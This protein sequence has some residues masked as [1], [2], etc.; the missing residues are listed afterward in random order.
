M[1]KEILKNAYGRLTDHL[2]TRHGQVYFLVRH[3]IEKLI[4]NSLIKSESH[5]SASLLLAVIFFSLGGGLISHQLLVKYLIG[6][7]AIEWQVIWL[8]KTVFMT[9][10]MSMMGII[11]AVVWNNLF[12]DKEDYANLL[13]LPVRISKIYACKFLSALLFVLFVSVL[14]NLASTVV[15]TAYLSQKLHI[16]PI[17]FAFTHFLSN[18]LSN[19]FM[20]FSIA[21]IHGIMT[22]LFNNRLMKNLSVYFQVIIISGFTGIFFWLPNNAQWL[23]EMKEVKASLITYLPPFWFTGLQE[24]LLNS[25]DTVLTRLAPLAVISVLITFVLYFLLFPISLRKY[26]RSSQTAT[27]Y[28]K[29]KTFK[30]VS[31]LRRMFMAVF[32]RNSIQAGVFYFVLVIFRRNL[33]VKLQLGFFLVVPLAFMTS[34][35]V[36]HLSRQGLDYFEHIDAFLISIPLVLAFFLVVGLRGVIRYPINRNANWVIRL[37]ESA[38]KVDYVA[39]VKKAVFF[40]GVFPFFLLLFVFYSYFWG[41]LPAIFHIAFSTVMAVLLIEACFFNYRKMPFVSS[42]VPGNSGLKYYLI[43][44][45]FAFIIYVLQ[46]TTV[47][48]FLLKHPVYYLV[49]YP[50]A[51]M[52]YAVFK[53]HQ[54]KRN[55]EYVFVYEEE[56]EPYFLSLDLDRL[57]GKIPRTI[58]AH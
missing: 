16:N 35:M 15:F 1:K 23:T 29:F 4:H 52:V 20:F 40:F 22:V 39:G 5:E 43:W 27:N 12:L 31:A 48:L 34:L 57:S 53:W 28:F 55:R 24:K 21:T 14:F 19:I 7:V 37:T 33:K 36:Y 2:K 42:Y 51:A 8:E 9:F 45:V 54:Y 44:V 50:G 25:P 49:F 17:Y 56:P 26:M 47:G 11:C 46:F 30:F 32:L 18:L 3:F 6:E 10:M 58:K 38:R 13:S 41:F